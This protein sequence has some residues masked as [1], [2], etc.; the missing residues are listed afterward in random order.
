MELVA[1]P[2]PAA[3]AEMARAWL[4]EAERDN[5]LI[6]SVLLGAVRRGDSQSRAWLVT[7]AGAPL[8]ALWQSPPHYLALSQGSA[9]AAQWAAERLEADLPG[10]FGTGPVA[11]AFAARRAE[12]RRHA[13]PLNGEMT[14]YTLERLQPFDR[15][16]GWLRRAHPDEF[17]ALV[18]LAAAAARDM[19]LP[20]PEQRPVEVERG[21]R[22]AIAE[23]KQFVWAEA[24]TVCAM[25]SYVEA[26][27]GAGARIRGVYTPAE[28]RGRGYG[29]AVTGA[30]A[31]LLLEEG[32]AWVSLFAD[33][34]NPTSTGI[35]RR[36]GFVPG[37][38]FRSWRFE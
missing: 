4:A 38:V 22:R 27:P 12:C 2:T 13:T 34:A 1:F 23:G 18:P 36:L 7:E 21:L 5:N 8:L 33:N 26:L 24:S 32:Q 35:Y 31:E 3:F 10:V 11:D 15:P 14:F 25:A 30:L 20:L 17:P 29:T 9:K 37:T 19:N 16:R 28:L 6:L